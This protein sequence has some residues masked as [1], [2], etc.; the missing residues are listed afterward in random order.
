MQGPTDEAPVLTT[1]VVEA[2]ASGDDAAVLGAA[3]RS[4]HDQRRWAECMAH[5]QSDAVQLALDLLVQEPDLEGFFRGF[6]RKM[7][8][9]TESQ[10]CAVWLMDAGGSACE[11]WMAIVQGR[12]YTKN[13]PEWATITLPRESMAAHLHAF[14]PGWTETVEYHAD[15]AR[16]PGPVHEFNRAHGVDCLLVSP[17]ALPGRVFGWVALAAATGGSTCETVWR[18]AL[19]EAMARQATLA[20]HYHRVVEQKGVEEHRKAV[21]QERNRIA[22]DI[23]DSLAQGFAAILMQLQ[24]AQRAAGTALPPQAV[25]SLETAVELARTHMIEARRSVS[26]LRPQSP[27]HE[28]LEA[29]L[30]RVVDLAGRTSG[31]PIDLTIQALPAFGA[32][33]EREIAGIAQEAVT[34]A[35]R[36]ARARRIMVRAE[37]VRAV[38]FR[39]SIADDG[40][41]FHAERRGTGFGMTSM[42]ERAERIG[43]S[44]TI[45]TA[46]R[47]GTEVVLAWEPPSF[48][49]PRAA[50]D[51]AE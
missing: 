50:G 35:V 21:L 14:Q 49:I 41:G 11:L 7:V 3:L 30:A 33:V 25:T 13:V 27:D 51:G 18:R 12:L 16:L 29:A 46:P 23:H 42:R 22:R 19:V 2:L 28:G 31:L 43:A 8:E 40:R 36:H 38:G 26:A 24:A 6:M 10:A 39:L 48:S 15:D 5:I 4:E 20:L 34:N 1:D 9:E 17:L 44:L 47:A 45:V 32:G 37:G